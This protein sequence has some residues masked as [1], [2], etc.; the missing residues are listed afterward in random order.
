MKIRINEVWNA[1]G[2]SAELAT[3]ETNGGDPYTMVYSWI[4]KN[5]PDLPM[6]NGLWIHGFHAEEVR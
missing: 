1:D 6:A 3:I 5:R 2:R 4:A